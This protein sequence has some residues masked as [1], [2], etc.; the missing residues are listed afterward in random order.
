MKRICL[1]STFLF[2][3]GHVSS[4]Q[5][6]NHITLP[7]SPTTLLQHDV[8]IVYRKVLHT[9]S[10]IAESGHGTRLEEN[11]YHLLNMTL[12]ETYQNTSALVTMLSENDQMKKKT[13]QKKNELP[14]NFA[15]EF[16]LSLEKKVRLIVE[17]HVSL[18]L[19]DLTNVHA[20]SS[21]K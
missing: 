3:P 2:H 16:E 20:L 11:F 7:I 10:S 14:P 5:L 4:S 18:A 12:Q 15:I 1:L 9:F 21:K 13:V 6:E 17:N 8:N 19:F